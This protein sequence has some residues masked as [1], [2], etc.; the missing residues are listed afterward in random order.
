ML[1]IKSCVRG[2]SFGVSRRNMPITAP[3]LCSTWITKTF[4]SFPMKMAQ[5]LLAGRIPRISTGTT[6]FFIS[7]VYCSIFEKTSLL[8]WGKASI[9]I[10]QV[11]IHCQSIPAFSKMNR[12]NSREKILSLE[13]LKDWRGSLKKQGRQLVATNGCFDLLH[14]GHVTYLEAAK[15]QGDALLVAVNSDASVK[16]LK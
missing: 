5:P 9:Q 7:S 3:M 16:G 13:A 11:E 1:L 4:S 14:L 2:R 6:S 10:P 12:M 15:S 8:L